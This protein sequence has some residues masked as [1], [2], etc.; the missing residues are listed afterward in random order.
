MVVTNPL[1]Y[2]MDIYD[3]Y[4]YISQEKWHEVHMSMEDYSDLDQ[5][6]F[7]K[8]IH[9]VIKARG[10]VIKN[11]GNHHMILWNTVKEMANK[12]QV[13]HPM[14]LTNNVSDIELDTWIQESLSMSFK[15][16]GEEL[17]HANIDNTQDNDLVKAANTIAYQKTFDDGYGLGKYI[18]QVLSDNSQLTIDECT[19]MGW[20]TSKEYKAQCFKCKENKECIVL[21]NGD[22]EAIKCCKCSA[23]ESHKQKQ[24]IKDRIVDMLALMM[25]VGDVDRWCWHF[26]LIITL[27]GILNMFYELNA[28]HEGNPLMIAAMTTEFNLTS[29]N[30]ISLFFKKIICGTEQKNR[31]FDRLC[32]IAPYFRIGALIINIGIV[33]RMCHD[34]KCICDSEDYGNI[35]SSRKASVTTKMNSLGFNPGYN[36]RGLAL[37]HCWGDELLLTQEDKQLED[38]LEE[39]EL[40]TGIWCDL[41]QHEFNA[42]LCQNEYRDI[43]IILAKPIYFI[44]HLLSPEA[45]PS[46]LVMSDWAERG[47]VAQEMDQCQYIE[48]ISKYG[49]NIH[50][51]PNWL[52]N[53][54]SMSLG[55]VHIGVPR[56]TYYIS[57]IKRIWRRKEDIFLTM[58]WWS[59]G[60]I[61]ITDMISN[62]C[63]GI[64][65]NPTGRNYCWIPGSTLS[66]TRKLNVDTVQ[67]NNGVLAITGQ[68][69][70]MDAE[71]LWKN[72]VESGTRIA[73]FGVIAQF[74]NKYR[75]LLVVPIKVNDINLHSIVPVEEYTGLYHIADELN[76]LVLDLKINTEVKTIAVAGRPE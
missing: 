48:L 63:T 69:Q 10:E 71:E 25:M 75:W 68:I 57:L 45:I 19:I 39:L 64:N 26:S 47:W 34:G 23:R 65:A 6:T 5:S 58:K 56:T 50:Y 67:L 8:Y 11:D 28:S 4:D 37:S 32:S 36:C 60:Q 61:T 20:I 30:F 22:I 66:K 35:L 43:V 42:E 51:D 72:V 7:D 9:N 13:G 40:Y 46:I 15:K 70:V 24:I 41:A 52:G 53:H 3:K 55:R 18:M 14:F 44:G 12:F 17:M 2:T 33:G 29:T 74:I 31:H 21:P 62:A 76:G 38:V 16:G 73:T 1:Q 54:L 59:R 27:Q 49:K